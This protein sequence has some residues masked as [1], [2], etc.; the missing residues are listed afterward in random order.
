MLPTRGPAE[1]R[2]SL[3]LPGAAVTMLFQNHCGC[4][5]SWAWARSYLGSVRPVTTSETESSVDD[6]VTPPPPVLDQI[7]QKLGL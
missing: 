1:G 6:S 5:L 7:K 3:A 4:M 2:G